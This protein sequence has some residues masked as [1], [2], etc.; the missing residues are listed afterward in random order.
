MLNSWDLWTLLF[1]L[2]FILNNLDNY[3]SFFKCSIS[4]TDVISVLAFHHL[5]K[6]FRSFYSFLFLQWKWKVLWKMSRYHQF[7]FTH[8]NKNLPPNLHI[9]TLYTLKRS[10]IFLLSLPI[11]GENSKSYSC[12][13]QTL[14]F[15][16]HL[17]VHL[18][19]Y[20]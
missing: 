3:K 13:S 6:L 8:Q 2:N 10:S 4:G 11:T 18:I 7:I 12:N 14:Q 20:K 1:K 9:P 17:K 19:S 5:S 15:S 16:F